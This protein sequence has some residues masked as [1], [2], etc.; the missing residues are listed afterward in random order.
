MTRDYK[1]LLLALS[2]VLALCLMVKIDLF[3]A[4]LGRHIKNG[5]IILKG[6]AEVRKAVLTT[7][8]YSYT[9]PSTPF[10]NHHWLS[11]VVFFIVHKI[12]G[13]SGL[14]IFYIACMLVAFLIIFDLA[15]RKANLL[16]VAVISTF[17]VPV[18]ASR[19]EV[20]PEVFTYLLS[21]LFVWI[22]FKYFENEIDKKWLWLLPVLQAIWVNLHI[23]FIL[24][25]FIVGAFFIGS[26]IKKDFVK[27]RQCISV[28]LLTGLATL[29]NPSFI[30]GALYPFKIFGIYTYRVLENQSIIFL[31]NLGVG[32]PLTF[33]SY[34][35]LF[36]LVLASYVL[37][38]LTNWRRVSIPLLIITSAFAYMGF[39]AIRDFPLFG[40]VGVIAFA[41]NA[42]IISEGDK[43][44]FIKNEKLFLPVSMVLFLAGLVFIGGLFATR[45]TNFGIS[46]V[47]GVKSSA[48][49][50][51]SNNIKGPIFN[52][53]D[54][55]GYLI[56]NLYPNNE[57]YFD[58]RPEAYSKKFV[59]EE[60]I[61]PME[62]PNLFK[63]IS[64]KYGFNAIFF[65]YRDYT[66]WGQAFITQKVFDPEWAPVYADSSVIIMLKRNTGNSSIIKKYEI[67][68]DSFKISK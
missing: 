36:V 60:Y 13:F 3:T 29:A 25:P 56:Y 47:D 65:Y 4:D 32:N 2:A 17:A 41:M 55:G 7:N 67:S 48:E 38:L 9:E 8:Y 52:N 5:E 11:G 61:K 39:T 53:Y 27:A 24:G 42:V 1:I 19:A 34:E 49:F 58:N 22:C 16:V 18:I 46:T 21:A 66:P 51:I 59:D 44:K 57:V 33:L 54:V 30:Y 31:N 20:R 6:S 23:G 43:Y 68:S 45:S 10:I 14:S 37:A 50:F 40:L 28:L 35:I 26:I 62:N 12:T 15:R 64:D 63:E